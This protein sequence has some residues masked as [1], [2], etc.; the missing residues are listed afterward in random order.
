MSNHDELSARLGFYELEGVSRSAL[1]GVRRALGRR[2]D[3]ALARFYARVA[4]VPAL[5]RFFGSEAHMGQARNAQK[6]HWLG[7]FSQGINE[8]Y[9]AR[10][11][12]I[13]RT[14]ARIGLEPKWYIGGYALVLEE[15]I[16]AMVMP[17]PLRLLPWR[18]AL[19]RDLAALVKVSFLDM[20]LALSAYFIDSEEKM[21]R[22]VRD[23]LGASLAELARGNL[24]ARATG[25]P[26]EYAGVESDFNAAALALNRALADVVQGIEVMTD[27]SRE[28]RAASDDLARRTEEQ[29]SSLEET[30][31]AIGEVTAGVQ[32]TARTTGDARKAIAGAQDEATQGR[33]I[34]S[35]AIAAMG[36]IEASS[37]KIGQIITVIDGIAFQ[38]NLLA[39]NAGVEAA[40]AGEAGKGFAVVASE[41]RALAQRSAEAA[42][43][44][45][46]LI[47]GSAR[48][49][50][51]GASLV[52]DTGKA[53]ASITERIGGLR[54]AV[55]GMAQAAEL[56]A[57]NLAQINRSVSDVDRMTQQ[58]AAMAEQCTAAAR[59]LAEQA[60][61][62]SGTVERFELDDTARSFAEA[63]R[64]AA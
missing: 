36:Q 42:N 21:R 33:E 62:L 59:S 32:D 15:I 20:D 38:T 34:V 37:K 46:E 57:A 35:Q 1:A 26:A 9:A 50:S 55:D 58:N 8:A 11:V 29:A 64:E 23:Q 39:L 41:V 49:V 18:R 14:H 24:R 10:A 2:I 31:R 5:S 6:E 13:G 47:T 7:A 22:I 27:G 16:A 12:N 45:K 4:T 54:E 53:L 28:I 43:D 51:I 17:G 52:D 30:A 60:G 3:T 63:H 40:R 25:L 19:A 48:Q 61:N 44:I 56:Q